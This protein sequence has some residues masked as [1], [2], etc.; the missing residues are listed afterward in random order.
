MSCI[1]THTKK[2]SFAEGHLLSTNSSG[3]AVETCEIMSEFLTLGNILRHQREG[4]FQENK[5]KTGASACV[6]YTKKNL[7]VWKCRDLHVGD[8]KLTLAAG[9]VRG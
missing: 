4:C 3:Q 7:S 9:C 1:H 6:I 5:V 8:A 2:K